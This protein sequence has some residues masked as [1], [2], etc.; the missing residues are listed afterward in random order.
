MIPEKKLII[1]MLNVLFP[2]ATIYLFGSRARG[3]YKPASDIDLALDTGKRVSSLEIAK[4][5]NVLE[6]LNI[7][8][9]ID[10]VDLH[11]ISPEFRSIIAKEGIEWKN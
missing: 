4:A 6:A 1:Q 10:L 8:Q 7:P 3:N 2:G 5:K 9:T 11:S